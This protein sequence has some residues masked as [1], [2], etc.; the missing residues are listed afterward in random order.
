MPYNFF[1]CHSC[2]CNSCVSESGYCNSCN[3]V[4]TIPTIIS[5]TPCNGCQIQVEGS[6]TFYSGTTTP[7]LGIT[8]NTTLDSIVQ[9]IDAA[10]CAIPGV[11]GIT[12][13]IYVV[14]PVSGQTTVSTN[15][16]G[17]ST[18]YTVGVSPNIINQ[19]TGNTSA[20]S[21][22]NTYLSGVTTTITSSS[23]IVTNPSPHVWNIEDVDAPTPF[24]GGITYADHTIHDVYV[25]G[26]TMINN[27]QNFVTKSLITENDEIVY[28]IV[29]QYTTSTVNPVFT[30][31]ILN[32]STVLATVFGSPHVATGDKNTF[33]IEI[34]L[35]ITDVSIPS[36]TTAYGDATW[37]EAQ[38]TGIGQY[39]AQ[40]GLQASTKSFFGKTISG[41]DLTALKV[42][43]VQTTGTPSQAGY[44]LIKL[45][46]SEVIKKY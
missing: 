44:N 13:K 16:I 38:P 42:T 26:T 14:S 1:S 21:T 24:Y 23:L 46:T 25:S 2:G 11:S 40:V 20:I 22:I 6:C 29:G 15:T 28:R 31:N 9:K 45:F 4:V 36:S 17:N 43:I 12:Q 39:Q 5:D 27:T 33:K 18:Y 32:G 35:H 7:C 34:R 30:I 41:I 37:M 19:I 8:T 3:Q 10:I